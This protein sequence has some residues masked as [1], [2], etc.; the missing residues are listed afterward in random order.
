MA[1]ASS[2]GSVGAGGGDVAGHESGYVQPRTHCPHLPSTPIHPSH[3]PPMGTPCRSCG[4]LQENWV[5]LICQAVE[6]GRYIN[7]HMLAHSK[8]S[9]HAIAISHSDLSIWCFK[10]DAYLDAQAIP[11]LQP[12]FALMYRL[13]FGEAPPLAHLSIMAT[14]NVGSTN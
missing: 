10:C 6:C 11:Q 13:K 8:T 12:V 7:G 1:S 4:A 3:Y 5:C 14:P 9:D 2:L